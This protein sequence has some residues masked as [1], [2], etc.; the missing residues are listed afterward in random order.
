MKIFQKIHKYL[1]KEL[2]RAACKS[3][4]KNYEHYFGKQAANQNYWLKEWEKEYK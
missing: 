2:D 1:I 4:R 3:T